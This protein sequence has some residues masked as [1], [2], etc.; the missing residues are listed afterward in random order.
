MMTVVSSTSKRGHFQ[1][2]SPRKHTTSDITLI[3]KAAKSST[4]SIAKNVVHSTLENQ[5]H[6][7][8]SDSTTTGK[9]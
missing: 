8:T 7:L 5:K 6:H 1:V 4:S 2:K 3:A 9:M